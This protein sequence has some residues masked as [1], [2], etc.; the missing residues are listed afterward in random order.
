M[1]FFK[2]ALLLSVRIK[3]ERESLYQLLVHASKGL[4][5]THYS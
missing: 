5:I 1:I 2:T 4:R 3:K